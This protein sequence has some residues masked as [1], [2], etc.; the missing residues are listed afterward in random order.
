MKST[1]NLNFRGKFKQYD[2]DGKP[3]LYRIGDSVEFNG[4]VYVAV[5]P[6][7]SRI[8]G[9][10]EGKSYWSDLGD[11]DG[12]YI[13]EFTPPNSSIGDR[14]YVPSTGIMYTRIQEESNKIWVE[15]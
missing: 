1:D 10:M 11:S 3:Y 5:K 8:P 13:S 12:F 6:T 14:W 7:S 2:P 4:N 15:L 9:T